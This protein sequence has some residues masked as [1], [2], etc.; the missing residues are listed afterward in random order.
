KKGAGRNTRRDILSLV[1]G[2]SGE[3]GIVY[4]MTRRGVDTLT[5]WLSEQGAKAL[6]YH[7]GLDDST[8]A[9]HQE[10]FARDQ[11]DVVVATVA[12]GMGIDKSNV[13]YVVHRDMPRS[14]EAW[15]QEIGRAGR[16]GLPS[17]C[18]VF[19]SWADVMGYDAFLEDMADRGLRAETRART[20]DLYRM[21]DRANG[22]RHQALVGYFDEQIEPCGEAC[23]LC[24]GLQ[25]DALVPR[26]RTVRQAAPTVARSSAEAEWF[27]RLR[28]LRREIADKER[29]P[30][31]IVFSDAVL[32]DMA[33]RFPKNDRELLLIPGVGPAK[34]QRYGPA[35]LELLRDGH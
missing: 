15:Y 9:K 29:V 22:C 2:H 16:D 1:R 30:P 21:L 6:P 12:F 5:D 11:A 10:A 7:A 13:R 25:L 4:C 17:D 28:A 35:F 8:R 34:L 14:I 33:R 23:D 32:R 3:S 18:V 26:Q 31:Y 24:L 20:L 19:Y 27:E